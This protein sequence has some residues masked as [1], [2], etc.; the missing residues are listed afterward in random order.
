[1][2]ERRGKASIP[3]V[4]NFSNFFCLLPFPINEKLYEINSENIIFKGILIIYTHKT[5][6]EPL[7][8]ELEYLFFL[9]KATLIL[10]YL[11]DKAPIF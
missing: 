5:V 10:K 7:M 2:R 11:Q 3:H 9:C 4:S 6:V 1:M 8:H